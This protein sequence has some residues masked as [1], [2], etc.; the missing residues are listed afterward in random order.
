[1]ERKRKVVK[2]HYCF[3]NNKYTALCGVSTRN[4]NTSE[5]REEVTCLNCL[6]KLDKRRK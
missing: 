3:Y 1:M 6:K 5:K 4:S 2:T